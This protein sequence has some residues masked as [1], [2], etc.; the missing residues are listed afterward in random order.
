MDY[1]KYLIK[2]DKCDLLSSLKLLDKNILKEM[3]E[4]KNVSNIK[5][6]KEEI[7]KDFQLC[8]SF[9]KNDIFTIKYFSKILKDE[10]TPNMSIYDDDIENLWAFVYKENNHYSYYIATEIKK[11]IK[12][13]LGL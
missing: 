11:I 13:E 1:K 10:N 2:K 8:L 7:I 6:L 5:E 12:K 9:S 4:E 3:I